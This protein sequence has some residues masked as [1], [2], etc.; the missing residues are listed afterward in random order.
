MGVIH[1]DEI[2]ILLVE[3][4][5]EIVASSRTI[6]PERLRQAATALW[7][8]AQAAEIPVTASIV[9]LAQGEPAL[10]SELHE[11]RPYVRSTVSTFDDQMIAN[12]LRSNQRRK[13]FLGGVSVE[14]AVLHAALDGIAAGYEVH[15][16]VDLCGGLDS[17]SDAA[18]L[19]RMWR[20]GAVPSNLS[21]AATQLVDDMTTDL[22]R[23]VMSALDTY[24]GWSAQD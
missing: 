13:L 9:P 20:A 17:R 14:I 16:L 18:T 11:L 5:P 12:T 3:M 8:I 24:W 1:R 23:T 15:I 19:E 4:Q 7:K 21:T 22:G 10:I 2:Q 6:E